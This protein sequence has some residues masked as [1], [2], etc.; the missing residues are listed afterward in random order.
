M[1]TQTLKGADNA[2]IGFSLSDVEVTI[3]YKS[4]RRVT[5]SD[6][7]YLAVRSHREMGSSVLPFQRE[8]EGSTVF[9][10]FK[11]DRL[12]SVHFSALHPVYEQKWENWKWNPARIT[13]DIKAIVLDE[14]LILRVPRS[15][16]GAVRSVDCVFYAKDLSQN[17]GWGHLTGCSDAMV[18][19]GS[20]DKYIPRYL[21]LNLSASDDQIAV[22]RSRMAARERV[23]IY[24]L[25]VRLFGN[26]NETRKQDGT[27]AE[28]GVGK[29]AD[30][31]EAALSSLREF[32]FT[33]IWLTGGS[34]TGDRDRLLQRWPT[35]GRSRFTERPGRQPLRH[36]G[37]FRCL[38]RLR[39]RSCQ[40]IG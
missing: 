13:T 12:I 20:G 29:F 17:G 7:L 31:N 6:R 35:S 39:H 24:Q 11:A 19:A 36:Q 33:H 1:P 34:A 38:S 3:S 8:Q 27:L 10:P 28:N 18:E 21:E 23:R 32:G 15:Y 26:T 4:S 30:I 5:Q 37:F 9:L 16:F 14:T 2:S 22:P 40:T 25:F